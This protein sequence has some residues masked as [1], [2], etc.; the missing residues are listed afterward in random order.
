MELV[1][2]FATVNAKPR[3]PSTA[4]VRYRDLEIDVNS[5]WYVSFHSFNFHRPK[6][7]AYTRSMQALKRGVSLDRSLLPKDA[8]S[9]R[10]GAGIRR[11]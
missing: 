7:A 4:T 10:R 6:L 1:V 9:T 2:L 11:Q 3:A 8:P 5:V